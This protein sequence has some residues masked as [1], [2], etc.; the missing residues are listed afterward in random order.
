MLEEQANAFISL[1][2]LPRK[3]RS[4]VAPLVSNR[5]SRTVSGNVRIKRAR[6]EELKR[7][8]KHGRHLYAAAGEHI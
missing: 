1:F 7:R 2:L 3:N 5:S 4:R 8:K 6:L